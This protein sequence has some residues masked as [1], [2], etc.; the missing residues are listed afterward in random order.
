MGTW[1]IL[2]AAAVM[3]LAIVPALGTML[4]DDDES[5]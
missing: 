1:A 2:A 3:F 5:I 4:E